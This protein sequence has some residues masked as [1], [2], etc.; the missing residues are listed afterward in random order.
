MGR[1]DVFER[2]RDVYI[3]PAMNAVTAAQAAE[4]TWMDTFPG[5]AD[6]G[7][8]IGKAIEA[9]NLMACAL[10][11]IDLG[12]TEI[13]LAAPETPGAVGA[14]TGAGEP[15]PD[16]WGMA[17]KAGIAL[18]IGMFGYLL[19]RYWLGRRLLLA[20]QTAAAPPRRPRAPPRPPR[21]G[22]REPGTGFAA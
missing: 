11:Q 13:G 16:W 10:E 5:D 6:I 8:A 2:V 3:S 4:P 12:Y 15:P 21:P 20:E 14:A 17:K 22:P 18:G 9:M 19:V 7:A 1:A